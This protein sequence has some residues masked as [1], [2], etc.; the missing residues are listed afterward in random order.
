VTIIMLAIALAIGVSL[1]LL[2]AGGAI[3]AVPA[4][5]YIGGVPS[6]LADGYALFVVA[7]SSAVAVAMQWRERMIEWRTIAY[8]GPSTILSLIAVR[9]FLDDFVPQRVQMIFFGLILLVAAIA[10]LRKRKASSADAGTLQPIRLSAFGIVIGAIGGLLGVGGGFLMTPALALWAKLDMKRAVASSLVLISVNSFTGVAVDMASGMSYDWS[11]VL[12]FTA[13]T[14]AG[15]IT[16]TFLSRR[17]DSTVLRASFG[18]VVLSI[19]LV[20]LG[21]ELFT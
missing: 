17:I 13:L 8:F 15:I 19:G 10:M 20:V 3:V 2:G 14:T 1:G 9:G 5:V 21:I 12:T 6:H 18:W 11:Y 7:V 16:G 4:F